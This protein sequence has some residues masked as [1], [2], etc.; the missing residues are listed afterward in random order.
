MVIEVSHI[1]RGLSV[2]VLLIPKGE[3]L[4]TLLTRRN[5]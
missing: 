3:L 2:F 5:G 4:R 1:S